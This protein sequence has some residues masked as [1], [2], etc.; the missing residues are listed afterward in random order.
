MTI[1]IDELSSPE[2]FVSRHFIAYQISAGEYT[3]VRSGIVLLPN[4]SQEQANNAGRTWGPN[5]FKGTSG[6]QWRGDTLTLRLDLTPSIN[7]LNPP[8]PPNG[9]FWG[10][11]LDQW[12]PI[13]SLN[14]IYNYGQSVNAGSSVNTF[15]V[16]QDS[17][18]DVFLNMDVAVRDTDEYLY[19]IGFYVTLVGHLA[20]VSPVG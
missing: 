8:A 1:F 12:A 2:F 9:T 10:F 7:R 4:E 14:S 15:S 16:S 20:P 18:F 17:Q 3:I 6:S 19:R 13:A 5:G 11:Q